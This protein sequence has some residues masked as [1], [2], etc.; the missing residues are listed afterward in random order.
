[1]NRR[2]LD[3][4][5]DSEK[6]EG[7]AFTVPTM[8]KNCTVLAFGF[9]DEADY[10]VDDILVDNVLNIVFCPVKGEE[11]HTFDSGVVLT[12]PSRTVD[13]VSDLV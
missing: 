7:S 11:A 2:L 3:D 8:D 9:F 4:E 12:V 13:D 1:M 5:I 6:T 10:C